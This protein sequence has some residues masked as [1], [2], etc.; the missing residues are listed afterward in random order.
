MRVSGPKQLDFP[1]IH[2]TSLRIFENMFPKDPSSFTHNH[3][4][5]E[6][7]P[8]ATELNVPAVSTRRQ[9]LKLPYG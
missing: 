1:H 4:L 6:A 9:H 7:L 2:A 5:H 3:P 8:L